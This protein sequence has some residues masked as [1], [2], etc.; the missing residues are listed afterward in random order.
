MNINE[1]KINELGTELVKEV[2]KKLSERNETVNYDFGVSF[3]DTELN[4][5]RVRI[6]VEFIK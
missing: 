2:Q 5:R 6:H 4:E 3:K 1:E